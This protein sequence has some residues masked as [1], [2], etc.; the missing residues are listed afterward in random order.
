MNSGEGQSLWAEEH[1]KA[2]WTG[3]LK[4]RQVGE[5][6]SRGMNKGIKARSGEWPWEVVRRW[7]ELELRNVD[8]SE[9]WVDEWVVASK[10]TANLWNKVVSLK[11][12]AAVGLEPQNNDGFL[13][14]TPL[15][16]C[17]LNP[18]CFPTQYGSCLFTSHCQHPGLHHCS[19]ELQESLPKWSLNFQCLPA[20]NNKKSVLHTAT[21]APFV[22]DK[23]DQLSLYRLLI[24]LRIKTKLT[25]PVRCST[26]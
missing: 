14:V 25:R 24:Y 23:S 8:T 19:S 13:F 5:E 17:L 10:T 21:K 7:V 18:D 26:R 16:I 11:E 22:W 3:D 20:P 4:N 15:A 1:W 12:S 6:Y 9:W 2:L